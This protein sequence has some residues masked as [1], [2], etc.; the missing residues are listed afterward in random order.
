MKKL[1][2][3][4]VLVA[5]AAMALA[6]CQKPEIENPEPQSYEYTFLI[7]DADAS[8]DADSK[9][10]IGPNCIEW[11]SGDQMGVYTKVAEGTISGNAYGDITPGS[12][13][14]MK[15]Y[16]NQALAIGDY[17]YAYYP[18][19]SANENQNLSVT[20]EIPAEQD[21]KDDMPM[22][23]IPHRVESAL[24][25]GKQDAPAGKIKFANL[26]SVI[27]FNVYTETEEYASEVVTSVA[28]EADKALAGAFTFD[29]TNVNYSEA[30]TLSIS[31]ELTEKEVV[32]NVSDLA[33]GTKDE[34]AIVRMV[35]APGSYAGNVVVSTDKATYTFPISTAKEFKRSAI[36]PL[37]LNLREESRVASVLQNHTIEWESAAD[38]TE[39]STKL[40]SGDYTVQTARNG[41]STNP[42]VNTTSND[43]RVYAD[44]TVTVSNSSGN[45]KKLVFNLSTQ[46]KKRL[47]DISASSGVVTIDSE[48][49]VV[50][51]EGN[52]PSVTFTVGAKAD[53]GTDGSSKAGQLC[54]TSIDAVAEVS[55]EPSE[56]TLTGLEVSGMTTEFVAGSEF[57]FDGKAYAVYS[58]D[59]R[60][61]VTES[62]TAELSDADM[63]VIGTKKVTV[64]YEEGGNVVTAE[65][66][67]TVSDNI[68]DY[69]GTYAIVAY[70]SSESVYYYLTNEETTSSTKKLVAV[71]AGTEK[72]A[73]GIVVSASK[74]WA[75]EKSGN[76]YKLK[77]AGSEEYVSWTEGNSAEMAAEGLEFTVEKNEDVY[78]FNNGD[79]YLSLNSARGSDYFAMY[80]S[81]TKDLYLIPAVEGEEAQPT[82][83]SIKVEGYTTTFTQGDEFVFGGTVTAT[84]SNGVTEDVTELAEFSGYDMS[85]TGT[86]T[87]TVVYEG[88]TATYE[89]TIN[90]KQDSGDAST[91]WV[92]TSFADLKAGDQ[93][94]IVATKGTST[95]A[96]ANDNGT[97]DAPEAV[98]GITYSNNKLTAEPAARIIWYVGVSEN[99]RI[100]Y[101]DAGQTKW[102][103]C[104][105]ANNG[106]R[107]GDTNSA[108]TFAWESDYMK[109]NGTSRYVG[110]YVD[111]PDW[112]CYTNTTGNIAGQTFLFFVKKDGSSGGETPSLSSRNLA[113]SAATA[114]A[115]V[116]EAFTAPVLSGV[117]DGV[118]Y[119]SSNTAVATVDESTGAVTIVAAGTTTITAS[120]PATA[121]YEAGTASYTL[122]VS[123]AYP[124]QPGEGGGEKIL[125]LT[126]A[127]I[128]SNTVAGAVVDGS[129]KNYT[130]TAEEGSAFNA[131]CIWS[132]HSKATNSNYF[133]QI[134]KGE[135]YYIQLPQ[136]SGNI[137]KIVMT[138][139][140]SSKA[141]DGGSNT[142]TL[143][144][145]ET[146][147]HSSAEATGT[148]A[149]SVEI[150][151][152]GELSTGYITASGAVRIWDIE[153]TYTN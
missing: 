61:D 136:L 46:G 143:G 43:C 50:V 68:T 38:W 111:N 131:C 52:A 103:Y 41:G 104:T 78:T 124:E 57:V 126:N 140:S 118:T 59:E 96:L 30:S 67:I 110:V 112:R 47:S 97:S 32:A 10:V 129:Y 15:V 134:K 8:D 51:W 19:S 119:S 107:V 83:E 122:T 16:S 151:V 35:V 133:L 14:T 5:A 58:D 147:T 94:V 29:L 62:V 80:A 79:R 13:A 115:T 65:Y 20:M 150:N 148:G 36:K 26:G 71:A 127:D 113:F 121:E 49:W 6:S 93:V 145:G 142:A 128:V 149:S 144:F 132:Y 116:G 135:K 95:Y 87:V 99:N 69:S 63:S 70:R 101:A 44:G 48:N 55:S 74:L 25:S 81:Q 108:K 17:I 91:E 3:I 77:S 60:K 125:K 33:V 64:A 45:I 141:M 53:Y 11:E 42:T 7:G 139:S 85:A 120:A 153:I 4:F 123:A 90:A 102:L 146:T 37:G 23:A 84:L 72:P 138:V 86:Q 152:S 1:M 89:I 34:P 73:D 18:Y 100:F 31:S 39:S 130:I 88:K 82:V 98:T 66:D 24:N 22:V 2:N 12:P 92:A 137:K 75:V 27:E 114:T 28:F 105:N 54:F 106:I 109:H 76:V 21:G 56:V 40:I 9:A 117:T